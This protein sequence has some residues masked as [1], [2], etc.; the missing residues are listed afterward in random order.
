[1]ATQNA[2]LIPTSVVRDVIQSA[3]ERSVVLRLARVITM[4]EGVMAVPVV[5]VVPQAEFVALG[6]R[7][8][9]T[10]ID[11][12]AEKLLPEEIAATTFI[13]DAYIDDAGFPIWDS[14]RDEL[15]AAIGRTLDAA[16]LFGGG[17]ASFPANG[18]VGAGAPLTGTDALDAID[19][20]ATAIE[21]TGLTPDG[22]AAGPA[23]GS[24]LRAAY[25]EVGALP[26]DA[27]TPSV[28]GMPV[29]TTP[30]WNP[31]KGD[32]VVGA[33][34]YLVIGI[35]EDISIELSSEGVLL[36]DTGAIQVTAFQDDVT[37]ARV[38]M[39]VA[40]VIGTPMKADGS[41][42]ADAFVAVDWTTAAGRA[43]ARASS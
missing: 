41:G 16:V 15:A 38:H 10:T 6:G 32:A 5:S 12:S 4:P 9:L 19:K 22:V 13:P 1:M 39:R 7:K 18:V 43:R 17:P 34:E 37:L 23:I 40:C 36:D 14:A 28:Y 11:W 25:R 21:A 24:A 30:I 31:A 3:S 2:D 33:W 42:P 29:A 20:G 27:P 26:G 8:P 35:R